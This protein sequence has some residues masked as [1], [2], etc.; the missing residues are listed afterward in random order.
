MPRPRPGLFFVFGDLRSGRWACEGLRRSGWSPERQTCLPGGRGWRGP[1]SLGRQ[2]R[3]P[4]RNIP[5]GVA[6]RG[7]KDT[8]PS[9]SQKRLKIPKMRKHYFEKG[10]ARWRLQGVAG[11]AL[12]LSSVLLHLLL[13]RHEPPFLGLLASSSWPAGLLWC[14]VCNAALRNNSVWF[15]MAY[16]SKYLNLIDN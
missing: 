11:V 5:W 2:R 8:R 14:C 3:L 10:R 6:R 12:F 15:F 13:Q 7:G 4:V 9:A 16:P 1:N